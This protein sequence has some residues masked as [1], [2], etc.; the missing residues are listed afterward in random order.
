MSV[1][2]APDLPPRTP[3]SAARAAAMLAGIAVAIA[4]VFV[5]LGVSLIAMLAIWIA[6]A[7]ARRRSRPLTRGV[8]WLVG[9]GT[10]GA[11]LLSALGV[12]MTQAPTNIFADYQRLMDSTAKMPP[13]PPPEWL[14]KITPPNA[15]QSS[16]LVDSFARS[17][18]FTT[19]TLVMGIVLLAGIL[20]SYAGTLGWSA[21]MLVA[22][23][24][25]GAWLPRA[26]PDPSLMTAPPISPRVPRPDGE[27]KS[28]HVR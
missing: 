27:P 17:R 8:S 3:P 6:W 28:E 9:V 21:S 12:A 23:G 5:T 15:Q 22:Y 19:W 25:T 14:R 10:I 13:P 11:L 18:A 26:T 20:A 4:S 1:A 7:V 24:A 2:S 16:P